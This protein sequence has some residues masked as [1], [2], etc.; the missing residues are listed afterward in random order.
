MEEYLLGRDDWLEEEEV[1]IL[2]PSLITE[3]WS[4]IDK[5]NT[6]ILTTTKSELDHSQVSE[7]ELDI[8]SVL[9]PVEYC[10]PRNDA[11]KHLRIAQEPGISKIV[12]ITTNEHWFACEICQKPFKN[13]AGVKI[14]I[15]KKHDTIAGEQRMRR[16]HRENPTQCSVCD[17]TFSG[18]TALK[19][20]MFKH[21]G[22]KPFS[23]HICGRGFTQKHNLHRHLHLA[24]R[25]C[26][27]APQG[28]RASLVKIGGDDD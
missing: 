12:D 4:C 21:T 17:R 7:I 5:P 9:P 13:I 20:H 6:W 22:V 28:F 11:E 19:H 24:V 15:T 26:S 25:P 2:E 14:H 27:A 3:Y 16:K 23:C 18:Q 1:V 8:Q 10:P